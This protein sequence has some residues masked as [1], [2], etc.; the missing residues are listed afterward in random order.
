MLKYPK[1]HISGD[2][3]LE[4]CVEKNDLK[5]TKYSMQMEDRN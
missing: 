1:E 3:S 5:G 2:L 4:L